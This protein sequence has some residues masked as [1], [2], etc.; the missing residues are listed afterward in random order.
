M[1]LFSNNNKEQTQKREEYINELK[2]KLNRENVNKNDIFQ[3]NYFEWEVK[4][5]K[6]NNISTSHAFTFSKNQWEI[7]FN[8]NQ[9]FV[10]IYLKSQSNESFYVR[11]LFSLRNHKNYSCFDAKEYSTLQN[12]TKQGE[13]YGIKEF[14]KTSSLYQK[15]RYCDSNKPLVENNKL[16]L[17]IYIQSYQNDTTVNTEEKEDYINKL[18]DLIEVENEMADNVI[19]EG[20]NEFL[21]ENFDNIW[22]SCS[23]QF[24]IGDYYW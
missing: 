21:I 19:D 14:I 7:I 1:G 20:Y 12:F 5:L 15:Y 17:G 3:E 8:L 13:M 16:I 23:S 24:K 4:D 9:D 18:K 10:S 2:R 11:F 22:S 6:S